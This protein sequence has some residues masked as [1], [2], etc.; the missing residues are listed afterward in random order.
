M[1]GYLDKQG[2][3]QSTLGRKN[4]KR[5][6]FILDKLSLTYQTRPESHNAKGR[7]LAEDMK[8]V[9]DGDKSKPTQFVLVTKNRELVIEA[10]NTELKN[11][12]MKRLTNLIQRQGQFR[13]SML[14][15]KFLASTDIF[16]RFSSMHT[17][18]S[19][20]DLNV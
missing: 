18:N 13:Q 17:G 7:I 19:Q 15:S 10:N 14:A 20:N 3:G 4:W 2:G 12:W 6:W 1:V 5:R 9:R 8:L 16:K 11:E